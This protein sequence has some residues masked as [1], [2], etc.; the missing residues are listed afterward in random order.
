ME[1]LEEENKVK[2]KDEGDK[3]KVKER[4]VEHIVINIKMPCFKSAP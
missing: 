2:V 3:I 1:A 4:D